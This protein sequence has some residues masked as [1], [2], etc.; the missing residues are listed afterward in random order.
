MTTDH[1][2]DVIWI[3][4]DGKYTKVGSLGIACS[5]EPDIAMQDSH[6]CT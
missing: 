6:K 4:Q 2:V 5:K 3:Q 1:P